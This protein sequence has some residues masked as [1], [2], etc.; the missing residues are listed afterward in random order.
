[1][2][3]LKFMFSPDLSY[4]HIPGIGLYLRLMEDGF[5]FKAIIVLILWF[6]AVNLIMNKINNKTNE[7]TQENP[8]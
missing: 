7:K 4:M 6:V 2:K 1:M 3:F 8:H 5:Y